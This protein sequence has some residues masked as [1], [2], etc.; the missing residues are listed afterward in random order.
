MNT[1]KIVKFN[2]YMSGILLLVFVMMFLGA[3]IAYFSDSKQATATFTAGNVKIALYQ[4]AIKQDA[5]GN[6]VAD[7]EQLPVQGV[8]EGIV[9]G[10]D[11]KVYPGMT[12]CKDPTI[13]NI[14]DNA[15]WIAAKVILTDG[16]GDLHKLLGYPGY[17]EIDI[18]RLLKGGLLDEQ[19]EVVDWNGF[20]DVCLNENYAMIQIADQA[21]GKYEFY[22]LM[23]KP[24]AVGDSVT[25][26]E[27]LVFD[28]MWNN[29]HMKEL[30]QLKLEVLA[31][32]VQTFQLD[33][34]F[35][36]MTAAFPEH[37]PFSTDIK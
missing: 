15:E 14:G 26:F 34:C 29:E 8:A 16:G 6:W 20:E 28:R 37:F 33:S 1:Q 27:K 2:L 9:P 5:S 19:V 17:G 23:L 4:S 22:F 36:A 35:D 10:G 25:I 24:M 18:E 13:Y 30:A 32:G 12:V 3:T 31:F 11:V 7:P 21:N